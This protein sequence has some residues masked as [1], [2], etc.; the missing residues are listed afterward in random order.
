MSRLPTSVPDIE[1]KP[2]KIVASF[3]PWSA[4]YLPRSIAASH[5]KQKHNEPP[6]QQSWPARL[7]YMTATK[8]QQFL[9]LG[10]RASVAL[11]L[12]W[13]GESSLVGVHSEKSPPGTSGVPHGPLA[14]IKKKGTL[15]RRRQ[16]ACKPG[17]DNSILR[18]SSFS[19]ACYS[20][21]EERV[22]GSALPSKASSRS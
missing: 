14:G 22:R 21:H 3:R 1:I 12:R 19:K 11:R 5:P 8:S 10:I 13:D 4:N 7:L 17:G 6:A 20:L 9:R 16:P 15:G 18:T 2:D